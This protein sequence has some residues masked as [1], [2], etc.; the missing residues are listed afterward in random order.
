VCRGEVVV[1]GFLGGRHTDSNTALALCCLLVARRAHTYSKLELCGFVSS[2]QRDLM[3]AAHFYG[4][5][6]SHW[7][8]EC[9]VYIK[10]HEELIFR[11]KFVCELDTMK[12]SPLYKLGSFPN[13]FWAFCLHILENIP[14]ASCITTLNFDMTNF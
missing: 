5:C 3:H 12:F 6:V 10:F 1:R 7:R 2:L 8:E 11:E 14:D 9:F 4:V 13:Y